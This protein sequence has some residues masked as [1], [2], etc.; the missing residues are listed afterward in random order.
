[1]E[2]DEAIDLGMGHGDE[3]DGEVIDFSPDV[4]DVILRMAALDKGIVWVEEKEMDSDLREG[5]LNNLQ[6]EYDYH[7]KVVLAEWNSM[8][9]SEQFDEFGHVEP[10][11]SEN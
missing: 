10:A 7:L 5:F 6:N 1:M 9:E 3:F 11:A 4:N 8:K 2:L